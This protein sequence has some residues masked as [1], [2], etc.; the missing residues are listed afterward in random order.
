MTTCPEC[1]ADIEIDE[2]DV[3]KGDLI[4]CPECGTNLE[5]IGTSPVELDL[6]P[7]E[8]EEDEDDLDKGDDEDE[9]EEEDWEE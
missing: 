6:A 8:E 1:D 9:D 3:N 7:D 2:F 4:S 5:I